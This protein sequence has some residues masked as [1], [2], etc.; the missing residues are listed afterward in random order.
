[1]KFTENQNAPN[2]RILAKNYLKCRID[3]Q[4]MEDSDW[5]S[6][7]LANLPDNVQG[8]GAPSTTRAAYKTTDH[9][10]KDT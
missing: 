9:N 8:T 10:E 6:L 1:M 5:E 2:C 7:G 4:L 3:N